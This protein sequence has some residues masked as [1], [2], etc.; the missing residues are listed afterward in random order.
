MMPELAPPGSTIIAAV[1][2]F[3]AAQA[4]GRDLSFATEQALNQK[5]YM[6]TQ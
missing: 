3:G 2:R 4:G 6:P 1:T 5:L